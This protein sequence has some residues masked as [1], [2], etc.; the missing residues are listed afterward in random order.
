MPYSKIPQTEYDKAKGQLK[1][2]IGEVLSVFRMYGLQESIP[3]A[4]EEIIELCEQFGQRVRGKDVPIGLK[5]R[6]NPR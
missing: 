2:Q 4:I 3:G 5:T 1:L 6:R